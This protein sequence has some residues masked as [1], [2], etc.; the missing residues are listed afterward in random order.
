MDLT[1]IY[2][3][4]NC[5]SIQIGPACD[6]LNGSVLFIHPNTL[7]TQDCLS[8]HNLFLYV[9]ADSASVVVV[10]GQEDLSEL[11]Q[12]L[13]DKVNTL[14]MP[15]ALV[16]TRGIPKLASGRCDPAGTKKIGI[17]T[18]RK[19]RGEVAYRLMRKGIGAGLAIPLQDTNFLS[20]SDHRKFPRKESYAYIVKKGLNEAIFSPPF[21]NKPFH[22]FGGLYEGRKIKI[23]IFG[24]GIN[25][26]A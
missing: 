17:G 10:T 16:E 21:F 20:L 8:T 23:L 24:R 26:Y 9:Y 25:S 5:P 14:M 6:F 11:K 3:L 12:S 15:A 18:Y 1:K 4:S 2:I 19:L 7:I 22:F 13:R